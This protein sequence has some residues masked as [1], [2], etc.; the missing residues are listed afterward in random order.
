MNRTSLTPR[1]RVEIAMRGGHADKVPFTVYECMIAQCVAEREVRNR[2]ACIVQRR[3]PVFKTHRP[4]VKVTQHVYYEGERRFT[5]TY[6]ETP[7][8]TVSQLD[9]AAGFTSWH[10]EKMFK[11]PDD[12]KTLLFM[13]Q[14]ER[15]EPDYEAFA[16]AERDFGDDAIFRSSFGLEPLQTLI[17]GNMMAMQDFCVQWMDN[18]DEILKLYDAIVAKR[19]EV[20]KIVAESPVS[21]ANYGGNVVPEITSPR[22]FREYYTPHYNEAAEIMHRHGKLIGVHFDDDCKLLAGEIAQTDLDYIEAFTPA[23]S[24]D[25]TLAEARQ[26]WPGKVLWI[27]FPCTAHLLPR[28][29][30]AAVTVDLIEQAGTPDGLLIGITD[31]PP[32][33]RWRDSYRGIMDGCDRHAQEHPELYR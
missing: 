15:Y 24:T 14:D 7:V 2:G 10:H 19:R 18:R 16:Q 29:E 21:H 3:V 31:D 8:G 4:N 22:M 13:I 32:P 33:D 17:S 25:M 1:Q 27:N 28:D 20:Y 30:V 12:Y 5:R 6:Y 26:A 9:E 23:P 11:T